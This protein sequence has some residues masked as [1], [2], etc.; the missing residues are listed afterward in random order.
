MLGSVQ[1]LVQLEN[2]LRLGYSSDF[3]WPIDHVIEVDALVVDCTYGSPG[4]IRCFSQGECETQFVS[5]IE[6]RLAYGPV[7]M[8]AHRGT[9]QRALQ[10]IA[11]E[12]ECPVVGSRGVCR[13]VEIYR[14]FGYS[15][16]DVVSYESGRGR[17]LLGKQRVIRMYRSGDELPADRRDGSTI[18]LSAYRTR[19]DEPIVE[20]SECAFGVAMSD[21]ADFDGTLE[22]IRST[23]ARFVVT[24]NTRHGKAYDLASEIRQRLGIESRPSSNLKGREW[25]I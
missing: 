21:H 16:A 1:V 12:V 2:G 8:R 17:E 18:V 23:G 24:D 7:Y 6:R 4:S 14:R 13:E 11:A 3:Q 25:G 9:L 19:P 10:T 15:I 22:Y 5:L 20:Y